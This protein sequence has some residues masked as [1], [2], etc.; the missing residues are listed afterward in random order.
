MKLPDGFVQEK[1]KQ[2]QKKEYPFYLCKRDS[3]KMVK[4]SLFE[5]EKSKK[6]FFWTKI[7]CQFLDNLQKVIA[8]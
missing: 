1:Q 5:S 8:K 3:P 4:W 7:L 6:M 2:K